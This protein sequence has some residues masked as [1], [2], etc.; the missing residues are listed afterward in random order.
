MPISAPALLTANHDTTQFTCQHESLT[1]WL[2]K[3]ALSNNEKR[4]SRTHV[5]CDGA[6]VV[7]FYALAAGSV[8]HETAPKTLTRN[9]PKPIPAIVLGRLAV[10][11]EYQGQ[12]I[13][14][15]LLQDAIL[16][17]LNAAQDIAARVLLC[18]AIDDAA[19]RF[20][21]GHGFLQSPVEDLTVMLDLGKVPALLR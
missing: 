13:G 2:Q 6:R 10:D 18:H 9:M 8:Q 12:G 19:R 7:G 15:G 11:V 14:A 16:R 3:H 20:Y 5:V 17:A 4:G 1:Q 21:V